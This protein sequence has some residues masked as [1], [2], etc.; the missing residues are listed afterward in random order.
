MKRTLLALALTAA[1]PLAAQ[2][3]DLSYTYVEGG[4]NRISGGPKTDGWGLNG[5][6]AVGSNF[7]VFG[8]YTQYDVDN[9]NVDIDNWNLGVG[10]NHSLNQNTDLVARLGYQEA[11]TKGLPSLNAYFTEV[12]VRAALHPNVE[13]HI[14]AGYE[15][16]QTLELVGNPLN[17][18]FARGKR[19][20]EFYGRIGGQYKFTQNVGLVAD[21]KFV[22]GDQQYFV[23]PR[24]SF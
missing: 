2:A 16:A 5:S 13:G 11:K 22:D 4:Y 15:R 9:V 19:E 12:G 1:L 14:Y 21:V 20:G 23:G 18:T 10:Y 8:G 3:G 7:H 17:P 24:I 6:V